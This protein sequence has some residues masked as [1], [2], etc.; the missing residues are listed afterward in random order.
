MPF[1][2]KAEA[3]LRAERSLD[4]RVEAHVLG[5]RGSILWSLGRTDEAEEM[6]A[7]ASEIAPITW[8]DGR[9]DPDELL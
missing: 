9:L 5:L 8:G 1:L 4:P 6:L 2:D 3:L 7:R